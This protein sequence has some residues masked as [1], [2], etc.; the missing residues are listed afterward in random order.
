MKAYQRAVEKTRAWLDAHF[1]A[2][3][4]CRID[5][6]DVRYYY[7][8]PY[9]LHKIGLPAKAARVARTVMERFIGADGELVAPPEFALENR[10]YAMGWLALGGVV[11]E[12]FELAQ[13]VAGRLVE[14]QDPPCGG[15]VLPD[16]DAGDL[17]ALWIERNPRYERFDVTRYDVSP[18]DPNV[19]FGVCANTDAKHQPD[20][21][22][23]VTFTAHVQNKGRSPSSGAYS[24][25]VDGEEVAHGPV[26]EL[27]PRE[28]ITFDCPWPWNAD[29]HDLTFLMSGRLRLGSSERRHI[30]GHG[31]IHLLQTT[32]R[33]TQ[34]K[35][36]LHALTR[37]LIR[38][39][40]TEGLVPLL[41]QVRGVALRQT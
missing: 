5:A 10:I 34:P 30:R 18:L 27:Q 2:A 32:H 40:D 37:R 4:N 20:S 12:R 7:K 36:L 33:L 28:K 31:C 41:Q 25:S 38:I 39:L 17:D 15:I 6:D 8:T 14:R 35:D 26:P 1:D 13:A 19:R 9:L 11:S 29:D 22:E 21:G 16:E 24:W 23:V 3:G